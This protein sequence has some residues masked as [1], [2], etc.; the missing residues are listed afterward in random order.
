MLADSKPWISTQGAACGPA[1]NGELAKTL[2][3]V[4]L[5]SEEWMEHGLRL[6]GQS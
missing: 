3:E 2:E 4:A 6:C 5:W 1:G